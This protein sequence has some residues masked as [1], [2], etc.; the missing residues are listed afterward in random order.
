MRKLLAIFCLLCTVWANAQENLQY[1]DTSLND[2]LAVLEDKFNVKF[3]YDVSLIE[4]KK[5][6]LTMGKASLKEILRKIE[7]GSTLIFEKIDDRY[8]IIRVARGAVICGYLKDDLDG[9]PIQGATIE[10]VGKKMGTISDDLGFFRLEDIGES[11][12]LSI[13]FLGYKT[14]HLTAKDVRERKCDV[15][16]M[17]TENFELNEVVVQEYLASGILKVQ[18][19]SIKINPKRLD[20]LSG[21]AEPDVLQNIQLLPGI[22][23]PLETSSGLYIRGG[24]PDQNLILWD[25]IKM[26]NSDHFFGTISVFNPYIVENI[27]VYRSGARPEYGDRVSGV[28]DIKTDNVIPSKVE[29]GF[30]INMTH[31]DGYL[32]IPVAENFG[33]LVAARRSI[34]D[35][36]ETPTFN[37]FSNKVFQNTRITENQMLFQPEFSESR[38]NF[39][40]TDITFKVMAQLSK[41]DRLTVSNLFTKNKLDYAFEDIE[42]DVGSSDRLEIQNIGTNWLWNRDWSDAF[43]SKTQFYYSEYDLQ[44]FGENRFFNDDVSITKRNN[45]KEF[46]ASFETDW[47]LDKKWIFSNGYQFFSNQVS[48]TLA[49]DN[50]VEDDNQKSPTHALYTQINFKEPEQWYLDIGLRGNYYQRFDAFFLEPRVYLERIF[51]EHFRVKASGEIK[52]QAISQIIEF[53]T[54]DFGLENQIWALSSEDGQPLLRSDQLTAGFLFNKG[55]WNIDVDAYYKNIDGLTSFTRGFESANNNFSE[56]RS[57]TRG[58]DILLKKKIDRYSTW[59]GYT[60]SKTDFIFEDLNEGQSFRGNNDIAHA[61]NW[62]HSY[63]WEN[64]QF[65][66]GWKYRTGTPFTMPTG[67]TTDN[68]NVSIAYDGVNTATL[69]SYHRLDFSALYS[70]DLA[71]AENPFKAKIGISV[72][73]LYD[74]KNIL[75]R[76]FVLASDLD[77]NGV[78]RVELREINRFS[79]GITPNIVFRVRF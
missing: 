58:I 31:A 64:L 25:G 54:L 76:D 24:S 12:T 15:H 79:L 36:W 18:D 7:D 62:S 38:E 19:G 20:I 39:Y 34:T 49:D 68:G 53:A 74:R 28:I 44:Y 32:K 52:N 42:F 78:E 30:G 46:G 37:N 21:L 2:L 63:K 14:I 23:S 16:I 60:Y 45:I 47:S 48:Y 65:S 57:I 9:S 43:S 73:N 1:N 72:L 17:T 67:T 35:I 55:N 51:G 66:L 70:F 56:G 4:D 29:G 75:S 10:S 6:S 41:K 40:F 13:A 61:L 50:F 3:S 77:N 11:D 27:K 5:V 26:Y 22:E 69:P 71:R 59:L 33:I 8:Y